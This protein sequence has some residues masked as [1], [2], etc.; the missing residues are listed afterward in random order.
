MIAQLLFQYFIK[1]KT[2]IYVV[3]FCE[4]QEAMKKTIITTTDKMKKLIKV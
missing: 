1:M 4:S 2:S 3:I